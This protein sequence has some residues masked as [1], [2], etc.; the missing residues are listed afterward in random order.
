MLLGQVTGNPGLNF[1]AAFVWLFIL[2][3]LAK[4]VWKL[5][6]KDYTAVGN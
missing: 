1:L 5:A 2:W 6:I 4:V 3:Y